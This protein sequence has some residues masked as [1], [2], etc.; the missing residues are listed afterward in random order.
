MRF[1]L[2][3]RSRTLDELELENNLFSSF[4]RQYLA[5]STRRCRACRIPLRQQAF[6]F[7]E[8]VQTRDEYS[9]RRSVPGQKV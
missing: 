6:L 1:R 2:A 4:R 8:V 9:D 3:P 5:N 7:E